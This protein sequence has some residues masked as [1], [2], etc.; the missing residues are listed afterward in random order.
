MVLTPQFHLLLE[1]SFL[2]LAKKPHWRGLFAFPA[3]GLIFL[4][5]N[6][7]EDMGCQTRVTSGI[8]YD[9]HWGGGGLCAHA[10]WLEVSSV[11]RDP[12]KEYN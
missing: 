5:T 12:L 2:A 10:A 8:S 7:G 6:A 4:A 3:S 11:E 1:N 9:H